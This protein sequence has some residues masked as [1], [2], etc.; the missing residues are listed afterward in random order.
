MEKYLISL[1][2]FPRDHSFGMG[3]WLST[4]ASRLLHKC[5]ENVTVYVLKL[6][7]AAG[8]SPAGGQWCPAPHLKFVLPLSCLAHWLLH[9]S[10]IV[11]KNVD[12]SCSF[13]PPLQR[14]PGGGP[15]LLTV[16]W[17]QS[18][19]PLGSVLL[20]SDCFLLQHQITSNFCVTVSYS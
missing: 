8:P 17:Y 10:N 12:P 18:V 5:H 1:V 9:A 20:T 4:R 13:W 14:N 6:V 3:I 2:I 16:V 7:V 11:F 19:L 15:G